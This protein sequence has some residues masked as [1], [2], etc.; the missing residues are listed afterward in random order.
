MPMASTTVLASMALNCTVRSHHGMPKEETYH[1]AFQPPREI[2][3]RKITAAMEKVRA[4]GE[5]MAIWERTTEPS[6]AITPAMP[7]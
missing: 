4:R 5:R 2:A 6:A 7:A 1:Q 3:M